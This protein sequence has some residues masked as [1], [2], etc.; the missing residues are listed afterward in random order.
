MGD[1]DLLLHEGRDRVIIAF[2]RTGR[3]SDPPG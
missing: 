1:A 3:E 2:T